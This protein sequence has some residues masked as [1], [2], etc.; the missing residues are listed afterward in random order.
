MGGDPA[1]MRAA[2]AAK[3]ATKRSRPL[4]GVH[5]VRQR[6]SRI[7][8]IAGELPGSPLHLLAPSLPLLPALSPP[9]LLSPSSPCH[10]LPMC[11][12][13]GVATA[14]GGQLG[15]VCSPRNA[16]GYARCLPCLA[17]CIAQG[18]QGALPGLVAQAR[19]QHAVGV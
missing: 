4:T 13:S 10:L 12:R 9:P 2:K 1:T 7:A 6:A 16:A 18:P 11:A 15:R 5:A 3:A 19:A 8:L 14:R 17:R